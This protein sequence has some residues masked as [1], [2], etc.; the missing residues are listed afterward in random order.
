MGFE[1]GKVVVLGSL[2]MLLLYQASKPPKILNADGALTWYLL[3]PL[4][5]ETGGIH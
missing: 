5:L 4:D 2:G 1:E 3:T